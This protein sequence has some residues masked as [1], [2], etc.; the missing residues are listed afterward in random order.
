M[1]LLILIFNFLII[2]NLALASDFEV[3]ELHETKS[4]DQLVLDQLDSE[5]SQIKDE[6]ILNEDTNENI[7]NDINTEEKIED[8]NLSDASSVDEKPLENEDFWNNLSDETLKGYLNNSKNLKS[9]VLINELSNFL[10]VLNLD[11]SLK[12]NREIYFQI[13]NYFYDTG[14]ISKAY[15]LIQLRNVQDDENSDFY[16]NLK[17]NYLLSTFQLEEVCNLKSELD[18]NIKLNNFLLEK[19]DIF[20]LVLENNLSEAE[21]LNSILIETETN[22]DQNFQ[23]LFKILL[24]DDNELNKNWLDLNNEVNFDLIFLYSAIARIAELPLNENFL[25][26]D[27]KN[28]AIPIILNQSI[29]IDLRIKAA[30]ES[31][32]NKLITV[33]SLAAL[34]QSVDFNSRQLNNQTDTIEMFSDNIEMLMAYYFQLINIQIFPSERIEALI[35]FWNFSK[36]HDLEE[37]AYSLSYKIVQSI[38]LSSS[39]I[40]YSPMIATSYIYN[41]DF[42]EALKWIEFYEN[43]N[44]ID[45]ISS[46]TRILLNLYSA[47]EIE[48]V[49]DIINTNF[50]MISISNI[51]ENEELVFTLLTILNDEVNKEL[52]IDFE[53]IYDTRLMPSIFVIQNINQAIQS[54]NNSKFLIYS[55]ISLNNKEWIEIHPEHLKL[56]LRGY[57]KYNNG[58]LIKDI[59]LEIFE[60]YKIL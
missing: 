31:F 23:N 58:D 14:N 3:I 24:A 4:L 28:L 42:D 22:T 2:P 33:D 25:Q 15:N 47:N 6:P 55:V 7:N 5:N 30:N 16:E 49:L 11:F 46:Y 44:G 36:D 59:V 48:T 18:P 43:N 17:I 37:I 19:I 1:K 53:N 60:N 56:L 9:K 54:N 12:K 45:E 21:L 51:R 10:E 20:C 32:N 8:I 29:P 26:I 40:E 39:N 50:D 38:E 41:N 57:S 52:T 13:V 34:Y 27:S 35:S